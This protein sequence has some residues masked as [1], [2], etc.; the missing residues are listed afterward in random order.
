MTTFGVHTGLQN[1]T[2]D[3]LLGLWKRIDELGFDWISIWDH[4]YAAD[5]TGEAHCHEAIAAHTALACS[6]S[7]VTVGS[8]VYCAAYRHPAVLANATDTIDHFANG[9]AAVGIGGGWSQ[10]EF[11][12]YGI[13]FPGPGAR[14][15][16]MEEAIQCV[17]G[18]LRDETTSFQGK[19]FSLTDARCEPKPVR[20]DLPIWVGGGGE[21][22]TLRIAAKFADAWNVPFVSPEAFAHKRDVLH[23]HCA[24]VG[25]DP[26]QISCTV[27]VGL[28]WNEEDL[29]PQFGNIAE[30]VRPGVL[31]GSD[32][33]VRDH[34]GRYAEAG[35][36]QINIAM[37]APW[38]RDGLERLAP[39]LGLA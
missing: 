30:F 9:R 13:P 34:I 29:R 4:F 15:D 14:L 33:Q 25:R 6:T 32:D 23:R 18:L 11:D 31:M 37:R 5:G 7:R 35:A 36:T 26:A 12:A 17:R 3:E 22:R 24:D 16:L 39:V 19:Y 21:K 8:L 2:T 1:T 38:D 27:N 20:P 28:A 10:V